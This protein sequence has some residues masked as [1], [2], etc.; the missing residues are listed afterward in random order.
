MQRIAIIVM[1]M[2]AI[3]TTPVFAVYGASP[4]PPR[5]LAQTL[6]VVDQHLDRT[7]RVLNAAEELV[8]TKHMARAD[9]A[10]DQAI[11]LVRDAE[12]K[13]DK[14]L[15]VV[16]TAEATKLSKT[17]VEEVERLSAEAR[18]QVREAE[19]I[20]DRTRVNDMNHKKLRGLFISAD[21]HMD[22][23]LKMLKQIIAS[24]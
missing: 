22:Q 20:V 15:T 19:A 14:A 17:Q 4:N 3:V 21:K 2:L 6:K 24:L 7:L 16:R 11:Q 8:D 12:R 5:N 1:I 18:N 13:L 9:R 10:V 23:A